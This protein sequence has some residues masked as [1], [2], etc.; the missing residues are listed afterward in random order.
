M[1]RL[2]ASKVFV[3]IVERKS[4]SAAAE[5]LMMSR[6][7]VTRYLAQ[8]E[9]WAGARL[10]HRTTRRLSL[11]APGERALAR[12]RDLLALA[13][14]IEQDQLHHSQELTGVLRVSCSFSLAWSAISVALTEFQQRHPGVQIDMQ[15]SNQRINLVEERIDLALRI[16]SELEPNLIAR[17]LGVCRS[18]LCASP[19]W[20]AQHGQPLSPDDLRHHNCLTYSNFGKSLWH[21]TRDEWQTAVAVSGNLSANDSF[22]L[23]SATLTGAGISM[24]PL[25]SAAEWLARGELVPI[26]P[27]YQLDN[28]GIY[29]IYSSRRQ[30]LPALRALIDFLADWFANSPQWQALC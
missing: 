9:E 26:L 13:E 20:V 17:P 16:A 5:A 22:F 15:I 14:E 7:M 27:E 12:C 24:Q 1:D 28:M 4:L 11:T 21:F 3:T 29:G 18:V 30:L 10:L 8:M 2:I 6:G 25:H 23:L 19:A